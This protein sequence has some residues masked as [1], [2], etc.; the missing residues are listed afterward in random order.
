VNCQFLNLRVPATFED[1]PQDF[2]RFSDSFDPLPQTG[3]HINVSHKSSK[4]F[5]S[6]EPIEREIGLARK[7]AENA[8][9]TLE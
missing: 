5:S 2:E 4:Y 6:S 7:K 1:L 8:I 9:G 3:F